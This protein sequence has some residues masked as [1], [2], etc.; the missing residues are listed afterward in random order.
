MLSKLLKYEIKATA[1]LFLPLYLTIIV[2][3]VINLIFLNVPTPGER[4]LFLY[5]AGMTISMIVYGILMV[6]L[7]VMTLFVLIQRFYKSLLGDE[8]YLMFTLPV[9]S[10]SHI[11]SKLM[12]AI[13][14]TITSGFVASSSILII[15]ANKINITELLQGLSAAYAQITQEFGAYS[16]LIALEVIILGLLSIA[17]TVLTIYA[18][19]A[20]GQLFSKHK[21]LA[22]FGMYIA[23]QVISQIIMSVSSAVF[24]NLAIFKPESTLIS[25]LTLVSVGLLLSILYLGAFTA[26]YFYLTNFILKKKLNLE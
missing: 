26:G 2:F 8:G 21:Q 1:R 24:F 12:I 25:N 22:S 19:I 23:L 6:G 11:L 10:W 7:V 4:T 16:A 18:A 20:L 9:K 15:S 17:V 13:L 5:S 14:W 3:S